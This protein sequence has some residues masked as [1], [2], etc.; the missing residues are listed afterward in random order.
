MAYLEETARAGRTVEIT[1]KYVS[2]YNQVCTGR[3]VKEKQT[4]PEVIKVNERIAETKLRRLINGNYGKG[5]IHAVLTYNNAMRPKTSEDA[6]KRL[7]NYTRSLRYHLEK[8]GLELRYIT[9]TEYKRKRI[10]HH[11]IINAPMQMVKGLWRT[12]S[13]DVDYLDD[14]GQYGELARYLIKETQHSMHDKDA[15][16]KKRWNASR[17]LMKP[18]IELKPIVRNGLRDVPVMPGYT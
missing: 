2:R 8:E 9:A 13:V 4:R 15:V 16:F 1:R 17:N 14:S 18:E 11:M 7:Q 10:H 3:G 5:D 12:G 6:R